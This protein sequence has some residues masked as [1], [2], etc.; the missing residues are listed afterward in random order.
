ML[1]WLAATNHTT[2]TDAEADIWLYR[3][4]KKYKG[5]VSINVAQRKLSKGMN[6]FMCFKNRKGRLIGNS[7]IA[8]SQKC[9]TR[10]YDG[11]HRRVS[12]IQLYSQSIA[13]VTI[14]DVV[15]CTW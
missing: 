3:I 15:H 5:Y 6:I 7:N 11:K 2:K 10:S 9:F 8:S 13:L 12:V 14:P 4:S 1:S